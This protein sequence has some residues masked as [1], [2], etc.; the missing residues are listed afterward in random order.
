[1]MSISEEIVLEL[2]DL[3]IGHSKVCSI[4][5]PVDWRRG[6]MTFEGLKHSLFVQ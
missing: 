1:M 3:G 6:V 5:K 4:P 2:V